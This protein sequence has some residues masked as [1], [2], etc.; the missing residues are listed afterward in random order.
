VAKQAK[1]ALMDH[2]TLISDKFRT[3]PIAETITKVAGLPK[4]ATRLRLLGS[5]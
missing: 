4:S 1:A 3:M 5:A 2:E